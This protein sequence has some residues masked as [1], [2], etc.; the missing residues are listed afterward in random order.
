MSFG[1]YRLVQILALL[2]TS[3]LVLDKLL[4]LSSTLPVKW[5]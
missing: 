4:Y 1:V 5:A 3:S 2:M